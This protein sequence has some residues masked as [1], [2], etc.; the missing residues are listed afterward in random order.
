[1]TLFRLLQFSS[2][3]RSRPLIAPASWRNPYQ[4]YCT[5]NA[6]HTPCIDLS[7]GDPFLEATLSSIL[8]PSTWCTSASP[9]SLEVA[10]N[11]RMTTYSAR[12]P[13]HIII[14]TAFCYASSFL[15][16][17][18]GLPSGWVVDIGRAVSSIVA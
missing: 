18:S 15:Y 6:C 7:P 17:D 13:W 2:A 8:P 5:C 9:Q 4:T 12:Q 16:R 14:V 3:D 11:S 1:V 10:Q